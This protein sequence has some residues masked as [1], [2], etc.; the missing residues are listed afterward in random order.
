ML[1]VVKSTPS[2]VLLA[3]CDTFLIK[4]VV[5]LLLPAWIVLVHLDIL[6]W[7]ILELLQAERLRYHQVAVLILPQDTSMVQA[8]DL[9]LDQVLLLDPLGQAPVLLLQG[10][11]LGQL[12]LDQLLLPPCVL[13][14]R[15]DL[16]I[17]PPSL[18]ILLHKVHACSMIDCKNRSIS[19]PEK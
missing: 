1:P 3:C 19:I 18:G 8:V 10:V 5:P 2:V 17:G 9:V 15:N 13:P 7:K 16:L 6:L 12:G 14:I 11:V 4:V